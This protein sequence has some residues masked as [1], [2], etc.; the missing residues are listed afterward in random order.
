MAGRGAAP[1]TYFFMSFSFSTLYRNYHGG[2]I[3]IQIQSQRD[4]RTVRGLFRLLRLENFEFREL[5]KVGAVVCAD[6]R[7]AVD[8]H[9][10]HDLYIEHAWASHSAG[11]EQSDETFRNFRRNGKNKNVIVGE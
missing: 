3:A 11:F 7:Y 4:K 2:R 1:F 5:T 6:P 9:S 10:C 8:Q